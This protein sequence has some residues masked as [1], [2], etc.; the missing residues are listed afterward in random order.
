MNPKCRTW[1]IRYRLFDMV[2]RL[3]IDE[4][5]LSLDTKDGKTVTMAIPTKTP[6]QRRRIR[7]GQNRLVRLQL[8]LLR[9]LQPPAAPETCRKIGNLFRT[10]YDAR[11]AR[12][13]QLAKIF[14]DYFTKNP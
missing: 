1:R 5:T 8:Q 14:A 12:K 2:S 10:A 4:E 6:A 13:K 9:Q 7:Q 3:R 11:G